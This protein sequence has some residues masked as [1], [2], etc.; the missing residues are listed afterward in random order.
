MTD[1]IYVYTTKESV[2]WI[3]GV[4]GF[5]IKNLKN[6]THTDITYNNTDNYFKIEGTIEDI[7]NARIIIQDLEK[8]YYRKN[9]YTN[10]YNKQKIMN[11]TVLSLRRM[12]DRHSNIME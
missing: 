10:L 6:D 1:T 4:K 12:L 11:D 7:H 3:I 9:Y 8:S 5:R 2:G